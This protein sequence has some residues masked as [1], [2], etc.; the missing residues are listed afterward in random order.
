MILN[1]HTR[2]L[3]RW[4]CEG[5]IVGLLVTKDLSVTVCLFE[6]WNR[7]RS[8]E[9]EYLRSGSLEQSN[10]F[11]KSRSNRVLVVINCLSHSGSK[12][13]T[14]GVLEIEFARRSLGEEGVVVTESRGER[15][16]DLFNSF[17]VLD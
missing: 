7:I 9:S 6:L 13:Q 5:G 1:S 8:H 4:S 17:Y 16:F 12:I 11:T 14:E 3:W 10:N 15:R 2:P